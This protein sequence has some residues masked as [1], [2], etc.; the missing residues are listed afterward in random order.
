LESWIN[1][2]EHSHA[3]S[4][5]EF[6]QSISAV[7]EEEQVFVLRQDGREVPV[8]QEEEG[9]YEVNMIV[10]VLIVVYA[11]AT[12]FVCR[13]IHLTVKALDDIK[14]IAREMRNLNGLVIEY[15]D[16]KMRYNIE[17]P[18]SMDPGVY[19]PTEEDIYNSAEAD[20]ENRERALTNPYRTWEV[21]DGKEEAR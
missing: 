18:I 2:A 12:F 9:S 17:Y 3:F 6:Q 11:I 4:E 19:F 21:F 20:I 15:T 14:E 13:E 7:H 1:E 5:A 16:S 8:A 10:L